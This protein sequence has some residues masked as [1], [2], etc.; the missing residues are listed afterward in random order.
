MPKT[1][2]LKQA[3]ES[4][5]DAAAEWLRAN[6]KFYQGDHWQD[7]AGW[8]GPMPEPEHPLF[9]DL[10]LEIRRGFVSKN[11]ISEV[12]KRHVAG[13]LGREPAWSLALRRPLAEEEPP[14]GS[15]PFPRPGQHEVV[16]GRRAPHE[17]PGFLWPL[18]PPGGCR[19]RRFEVVSG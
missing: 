1:I 16:R 15:R 11:T 17:A 18:R 3:T 10:L 2:T 9:R 4:I 13:V 6:Q 5:P 14:A 12:V 19:S 8:S 7:G